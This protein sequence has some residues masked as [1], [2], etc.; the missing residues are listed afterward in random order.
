MIM[1]SSGL[2]PAAAGKKSPAGTIG[3]VFLCCFAKDEAH[4]FLRAGA[5]NNRSS[6]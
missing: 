4:G 1:L 6:G 5:R 3:G 2:K